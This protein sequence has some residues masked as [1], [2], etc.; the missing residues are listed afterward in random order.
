MT[1]Q[2]KAKILNK[3][4]QFFFF[5]QQW[6]IRRAKF[7]KRIVNFG[8]WNL[9]SFLSNVLAIVFAYKFVP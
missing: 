3:I 9:Y 6:R 2:T 5:F 4:W 1:P 8:F 7:L